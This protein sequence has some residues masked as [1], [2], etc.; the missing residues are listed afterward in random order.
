MQIIPKYMS[1]TVSQFKHF[2]TLQGMESIADIYLQEIW[3]LGDTDLTLK[4]L[5]IIKM[6]STMQ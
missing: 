2:I 3:S 5:T 4:L 1:L 6:P